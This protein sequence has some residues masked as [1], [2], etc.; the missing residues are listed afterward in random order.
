MTFKN[1]VILIFSAALA[2]R[3]IFGL[4]LFFSGQELYSQ[5][6]DAPDY[7]QTAQNF[8]EKRIWSADPGANPQPDNLRTPVYPLFL[9]IFIFLKIPLFFAAVFQDLLMAITAVFVFTLGRRIF[10]EKNAF[11]SALIF[12]LDPYLSSTFISKS[13]M[14]EP[15]AIFFLTV[16]FLNL[17]IF[18]KEKNVKNLTWGSIFLALLALTKPQFFFFV[19]FIG[20]AILFSQQK[21]K[22][23]K[24]AFSG[25][26]FFFLVSPWMIYNFVSFKTLQF[27]SVSNVTL[28][29][30]ADYFQQW[31]NKSY[32]KNY[33][34]YIGKA[35][36]IVGAENATQ[37]F[38]PEKAKKLSEIGKKTILQNPLSFAFYHLIHIPRLFWHDTTIETV[39]KNFGI[40]KSDKGGSD[41][42]AARNLLTGNFKKGII[43]IKENPV[44]IISLFLKI[45]ALTLGALAVLNPLIKYAATKRFSATSTLI[46]FAIIFYAAMISPVGQHRYRSLIEPMVLLLSLETLGM[47]FI[48]TNHL[49]LWRKHIKNNEYQ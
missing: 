7:I 27:S 11:W 30:I 45:L 19:I 14:T 1:K 22:L 38:R 33:E 42:E 12:A 28:Y 24:L 16:A 48:L 44:W 43:D 47:F 29:V 49:K 3:L 17:A 6:G 25:C 9:S 34:G 8:L 32:D 21:Q 23:K 36:K 39:S 10:S 40:K 46:A 20:L 4:G 13:I 37:L 5:T 31:K 15:I 18:I 35:Q 26:L 2:I 41:I